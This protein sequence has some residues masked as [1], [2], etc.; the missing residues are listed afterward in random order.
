MLSLL[1]DAS[2]LGPSVTE[3]EKVGSLWWAPGLLTIRISSFLSAPESASLQTASQQAC[4]DAAFQ[5]LPTTCLFPLFRG[6]DYPL[7]IAASAWEAPTPSDR[8]YAAYCPPGPAPGS[9]GGCLGGRSTAHRWRRANPHGRAAGEAPRGPSAHRRRHPPP[10][11]APPEV[12]LLAR[13]L[14]CWSAHHCCLHFVSLLPLLPLQMPACRPPT[15][16]PPPLFHTCRP[17]LVPLCCLG[18]CCCASCC[19]EWP[20]LGRC[21]RRR[22][23]CR[24]WAGRQ[25]CLCVTVPGDWVAY[26]TQLGPVSGEQ[27]CVLLAGW[28]LRGLAPGVA[29]LPPQPWVACLWS[30]MHALVATS[31][32]HAASKR[33]PACI[34]CGCRTLREP[35][36]S[37]PARASSTRLAAA[38]SP[39]QLPSC[40]GGRAAAAS[41]RRQ[42]AAQWHQDLP[43]AAARAGRLAR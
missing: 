3:R 36:Q 17:P 40:S 13:P 39:Q 8:S 34:P 31:R 21:L 30:L 16:L 23:C 27:P 14:V 4:R 28:L 25:V 20:L 41:E 10:Y 43:A 37:S 38:P 35:R 11:I 9:A 6:A 5:G 33:P 42:Q 24:R 12:A 18:W 2:G 15:G 32:Q 29:P 7:E 19:T 26:L 1:A 22:S